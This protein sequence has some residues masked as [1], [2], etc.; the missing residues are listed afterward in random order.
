MKILP[1]STLRDNLFLENMHCS[2]DLMVKTIC[3]VK[4]NERYGSVNKEMTN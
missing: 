4:R 1:P 3:L 2:D